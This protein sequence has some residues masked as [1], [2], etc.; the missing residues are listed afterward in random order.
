[1]VEAS[2]NKH[3]VLV[4]VTSERIPGV[5]EPVLNEIHHICVVVPVLEELSFVRLTLSEVKDG[6]FTW[7]LFFTVESDML[8]ELV[9]S[10]TD[11]GWNT[12]L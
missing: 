2:V 11:G 7:M 8:H 4:S 1:M 10:F 5:T 6:A 9:F 12:L 3:F